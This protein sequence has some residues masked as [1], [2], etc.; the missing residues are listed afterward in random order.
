[1]HLLVEGTPLVNP[2]AGI[3]YA[4]S[5]EIYQVV[6]KFAFLMTDEDGRGHPEHSTPAAMFRKA[7]HDLIDVLYRIIQSFDYG[8]FSV[9]CNP[10]G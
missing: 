6:G 7:S 8:D 9:V 4:A 5:H 2:T 3:I 10:H 1:M